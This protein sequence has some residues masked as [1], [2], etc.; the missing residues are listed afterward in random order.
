MKLL[1]M[2]IF[3]KV[4]K[5]IS[6][7]STVTPV[8]YCFLFLTAHELVDLTVNLKKSDSLLRIFEVFSFLIRTIFL[9]IR[10][11]KYST[12]CQIVNKTFDPKL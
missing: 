5:K 1:N 7:I 10:I 4:E 12:R 2:G 11:I 8:T 9:F 3:P 6:S